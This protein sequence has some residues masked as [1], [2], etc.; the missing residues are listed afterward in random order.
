MARIQGTRIAEENRLMDYANILTAA[1]RTQFADVLPARGT[2]LEF[3]PASKAGP[4]EC[5][6]SFARVA[7]CDGET[8]SWL[9]GVCGRSWDAPCAPGAEPLMPSEAMAEMLRSRLQTVD[10]AAAER[11]GKP[12]T[13]PMPHVL[14]KKETKKAKQLKDDAFRAL[15]WKLDG[16]KSRATGKKLVR[17]GTTDWDQLGEVDHVINRS[18]APDRIY[19]PE[20]ALLLSKAENPDEEDAVSACARTSPL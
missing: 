1:P 7:I 20:N 8:D 17:S 13:K 6:A 2:V 15:I 16:G 12:L 11:A 5:C 9:C 14:A 4:R 18:T 3:G 10:E 19:D